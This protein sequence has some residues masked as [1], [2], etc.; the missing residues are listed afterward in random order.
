MYSLWAGLSTPAPCCV[1]YPMLVPPSRVGHCQEPAFPLMSNYIPRIGHCLESGAW[2]LYLSPTCRVCPGPCHPLGGHCWDCL[3]SSPQEAI[4]GIRR[5]SAPRRAGVNE[6][7]A[8]EGTTFLCTQHRYFICS[9]HGHARPTSSAPF[10][11]WQVGGCKRP[12]SPWTCLRLT[13]LPRARAEALRTGLSS[14]FSEPLSSPWMVGDAQLPSAP[15]V[16]SP[17]SKGERE[18][19]SWM[20][21]CGYICK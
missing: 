16:I 19:A 11:S 14:L 12:S 6:E 10:H 9:H 2:T 7:K 21:S 20:L 5:Q 4:S 17:V 3:G 13:E 8:Q 18:L 1:Y 15:E